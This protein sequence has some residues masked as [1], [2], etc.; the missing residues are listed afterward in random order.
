MTG[1]MQELQFMTLD[2]N[3]NVNS[4]IFPTNI[5]WN[6]KY[7]EAGSFSIQLPVNQYD[8]SMK[9]V[10]TKDRPEM[11]I[12][13]QVN[14]SIDQSGFESVLISGYF[15]EY[16]LNDKV[17]YPT[18]T[19]NYTHVEDAITDLVTTYKEDIPLLTIKASQH[20][21]T[22]S[23]FQTI[24]DALGDYVYY[25]LTLHQS[26]YRVKYDYENNKKIFEVWQGLDRTQEQSVNNPV[27]FS[28]YFG[29]LKQPNVVT[30]NTKYKNYAIVKGS[31]NGDTPVYAFTDLSSGGYKN[32]V[33]LEGSSIVYEEGMTQ[34]E[35]I[36]ALQQYGK[37]QLLNTYSTVINIQTDILTGSY[38]YMSDFDLGDKC[39]IVIGAIGMTVEAR[40]IAIYEVIKSG[41]HTL[42]LEFGNQVIK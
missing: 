3:F 36:A 38:E 10:Y 21:G 30:N 12:I 24:G 28:T 31:L 25:I 23:N 15:L 9:Y 8:T 5:Q 20:Q 16:E 26:S 4:I 32:K 22:A 2:E 1:K 18:F 41:S 33:Y 6:R 39:D 19:A 29:N 34:E 14:Y 37:E 13:Q 40:I 27:T 17:I 35:Y 11:G 42:T 7:Y